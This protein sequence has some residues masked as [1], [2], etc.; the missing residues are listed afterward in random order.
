MKLTRGSTIIPLIAFGVVFC[1]S[2]SNLMTANNLIANGKAVEGTVTR[3]STKGMT[4]FSYS[5]A[6]QT[7]EGKGETSVEVG[8]PIQVR[9]L[10]TD[11][12][13]SAPFD[14]GTDKKTLL[15]CFAGIVFLIF[16]VLTFRSRFT[17]R[18]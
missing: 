1:W 11:P 6:G 12:S 13:V 18:R 8:Q 10:P 3:K 7:F 5:V 17:T 4:W 16:A 15:T 14:E 2:V 9:Y